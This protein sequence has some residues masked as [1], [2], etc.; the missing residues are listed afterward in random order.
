[1]SPHSSDIIMTV[2]GW[3]NGVRFP[4][5]AGI[6]LFGSKS[7]TVPNP[8]DTET[9]PQEI[10]Q[11]ERE[12]KHSSP[13]SGIR[14]H[15]SVPGHKDNFTVIHFFTFLLF[16]LGF[17]FVDCPSSAYGRLLSLVSC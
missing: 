14:R 9:L 5:W 12:A 6:F 10:M 3:T 8:V 1:M 7:R 16:I 2:T 17:N 4:A 11:P 15:G 13:P